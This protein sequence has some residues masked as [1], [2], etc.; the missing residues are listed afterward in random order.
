VPAL[1]RAPKA[2]LR[3]DFLWKGIAILREIKKA[4]VRHL[5][6]ATHIRAVGRDAVEAVEARC[7]GRTLRIETDLLLLHF[8]VI[9]NTHLFRQ[10]GCRMQ[11]MADQR[12]WHPLCDEWGHTTCER[13]FAAGDGAKVA[14]ALAAQ[15]KG[16]L[17]ALEAAH[18]SGIIPAYERDMLARPVRD[19]LRHD[20]WPRP[21]VDAIYAPRPENFSFEDATVVCRCENV[22][23]GDLRKVVA[24]GVRELNEA[25]IVT[26]SGMGP[27]QGRMCGPALAEVI[28]AELDLSPSASG[29]LNIR[30]PLKPV[31]LEEIAKMEVETGPKEGGNWLLDKK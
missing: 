8:G 22:T 12:Y 18:C 20:A 23:V 19:A 13:V 27:C 11:W 16:E 30:P 29:L 3:P 2:L 24:E 26:R 25:K 7:G 17:A 31:P 14:G 9:P 10:V 21:F 15:C 5:K 1:P 6:G 4:G 28:A